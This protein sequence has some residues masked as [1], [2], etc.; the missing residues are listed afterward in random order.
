V[1]PDDTYLFDYALLYGSI[2]LDYY[3]ETND[4][5]TLK[6]LYPVAIRQIE[7]G[8]E[9]LNEDGIV[10]DHS[11]EFWCFVDWGEG[12]NTQ[13]A[14]LAILIYSMRYGIRLAGCMHDEK[15]AAWLEQKIEQLKQ[16]AVAN[17]WDE[18]QQLF[19]SGPDRQ[20]SWA[21]QV[22]MILARVFSQEESRRLILH[23]IDVNPSVRMVSPYMYHHYIDA[24]I[25]C[26]EKERALEEMKRY[27]GG[28]IRAGAD[29]FWEVYNPDNEEESPYG[30]VAAN[31]YC[32][33][34]SCTP[35][36]FLRKF[37]VADGNE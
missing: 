32:H 37:Y 6:E 20:V 15:T 36:Y 26:G 18:K 34:W 2:L 33:A 23:T 13:A 11:G 29:T 8:L 35:S 3:E 7:I 27:W 19:V 31:S 24:L 22:W 25:R 28:M 10:P 14:S 17:F 12:L 1:E 9:E 4:E 21:T 30:S 16:S 5:D